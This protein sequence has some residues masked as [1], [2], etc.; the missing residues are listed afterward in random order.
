MNNGNK[1]GLIDAKGYL[2]KFPLN[3]DSEPNRLKIKHQ[4]LNSH[5]KINTSYG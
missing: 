4:D 2:Y 5:Y 3:Q 1:Q